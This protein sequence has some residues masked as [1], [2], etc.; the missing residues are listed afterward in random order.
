MGRSAPYETASAEDYEGKEGLNTPS[1]SLRTP[2]KTSLK[3]AL[4][5]ETKDLLQNIEHVLHATNNEA[6][7]PPILNEHTI[8]MTNEPSA[9]HESHAQAAAKANA[10]GFQ[11]PIQIMRA[12]K[13]RRVE[14]ER[15]KI[16]AVKLD[17]N[18][19]SINKPQTHSANRHHT[20]AVYINGKM[21]LEMPACH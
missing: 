12:K 5:L 2:A 16:Q 11:S 8:R 13:R 20:H 9:A 18:S 19:I 10:E 7:P 14:R 17:A 1:M 15:E 21:L 4:D 6:K 3:P